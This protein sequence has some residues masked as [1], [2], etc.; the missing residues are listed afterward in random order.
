MTREMQ[1]NPG[2]TKREVL[3]ILLDKLERMAKILNMEHVL[4]S[5]VLVACRGIQEIEPVLYSPADTWEGICTQLRNAMNIASAS[6]RSYL[7][8][9]SRQYLQDG[10]QD[11]QYLLAE[12]LDEEEYHED[13]EP[14]DPYTQYLFDRK[15]RGSRYNTNS[16][17]QGNSR[18][19]PK[20][21]GNNQRNYYSR[22]RGGNNLNR[23]Q[24]YKSKDKICY[25]CKKPGCW[26]NRHPQDERGE[27]YTKFKASRNNNYLRDEQVL[28]TFLTEMDIS[29]QTAWLSEPTYYQDSYQFYLAEADPLN[30]ASTSSQ[31]FTAVETWNNNATVYFLTG[32][33]PQTTIEELPDDIG[34][35]NALESTKVKLQ[36]GNSEQEHWIYMFK[37]QYAKEYFQGIIPDTGVAGVSTA[38]QTQLAA[39]QKHIPLSLD[40]STAGQHSIRFGKGLLMSS[41]GTI[42]VPT[43]FGTI[44]FHLLPTDTPFLLCLKDMDEL[45]IKFDNL[46][47][48]LVQGELKV[49]VVRRFGHAWLDLHHL[50]RHIQKPKATK[51]TQLY[52]QSRFDTCQTT[53]ALIARSL[54][55][56]S[57]EIDSQFYSDLNESQLR[58]LH[59]RFG[60]PTAQRLLALLENAGFTDLD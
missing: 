17:Q 40:E 26:S 41:L 1:L 45:S 13:F 25:V 19:A 12:D 31:Y 23:A 42:P 57:G 15:Y 53:L 18:H 46:E 32:A 7:Q 14:Q 28:L 29:E 2:K 35:E 6:K 48:T 24:S 21:F 33:Q 22:G 20:H 27:A 4:Q 30:N 60:H 36:V 38:G 9:L 49:P 50:L 3:E 55:D 34:I 16:R 5:Q 51:V 44:N 59:R 58:Q 8:D 54:L 11:E 39:L 56:T 52:Y 43:P 47:N 10:P 37:D